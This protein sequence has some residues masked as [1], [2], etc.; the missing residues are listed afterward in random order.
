MHVFVL[1]EF[2]EFY[3]FISTNK[4]IK[5]IINIMTIKYNQTPL[6]RK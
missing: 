5:T 6:K 2:I 1:L 4:L 3:I